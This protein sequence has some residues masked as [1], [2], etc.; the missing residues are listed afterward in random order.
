MALSISSFAGNPG[1]TYSGKSGIISSPSFWVC[2][3]THNSRH[4][5]I[6]A[7]KVFAVNYTP[8]GWTWEPAVPTLIINLLCRPCINPLWYQRHCSPRYH[9]RYLDFEGRQESFYALQSFLL[10][11]EHTRHYEVGAWSLTVKSLF[12]DCH[13][14]LE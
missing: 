9:T 3:A 6:P 7:A 12:H 10:I 14:S 1:I 8:I 13:Y 4:I 11:L 2:Y 5:N